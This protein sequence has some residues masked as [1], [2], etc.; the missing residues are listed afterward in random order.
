MSSSV[1]GGNNI[2]NDDSAELKNTNVRLLEDN[3]A[4]KREI[5]NL[6]SSHETIEKRDSKVVEENVKLEK[7]LHDCR[8]NEDGS[9][10]FNFIR[11]W[12]TNEQ[13]TAEIDEYR[14]KEVLV[15]QRSVSEGVRD[16]KTFSKEQEEHYKMKQASLEVQ[17]EELQKDMEK[18]AQLAILYRS[19]FVQLVKQ[20]DKVGVHVDL[21]PPEDSLAAVPSGPPKQP[22]TVRRDLPAKQVTSDARP[23]GRTSVGPTSPTSTVDPL[24]STGPRSLPHPSIVNKISLPTGLPVRSRARSQTH[25]MTSRRELSSTVELKYEVF[26]QSDEDSEDSSRPSP[27]IVSSPLYLSEE[28]L[29]RIQMSESLQ[30]SQKELPRL[31][32]FLYKKSPAFHRGWQKRFV[33]VRDYNLFYSPDRVTFNSDSDMD[34]SKF[35][36][37]ISLLVV[38]CVRE[39]KSK[40]GP[41]RRF[42][43]KARDP[44]SG[45]LRIYQWRASTLEECESWVDGLN[46]HLDLLHSMM[47]W[48]ALNQ[49][50]DEEKM[51]V[52]TVQKM[53]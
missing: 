24:A 3:A 42:E 2:D 11:L 34:S 14:K 17:V 46:Q 16:S 43:I 22:P 4:L 30:K 15:R 5:S 32:G 25:P 51:P 40:G 39:I 53:R 20:L 18:H 10:N 31:E 35:S 52:P 9:T 44:R 29:A 21:P 33:I 12:R 27:T 50:P 28:E 41:S 19:Y 26:R 23:P 1:S 37:V 48:A 45:D 38:R 49:D 7:A 13:L 8:K 6:R 36:N 47:R